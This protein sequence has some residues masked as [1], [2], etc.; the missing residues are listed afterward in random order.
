MEKA[1]GTKGLGMFMTLLIGGSLLLHRGR[2]VGKDTTHTRDHGW[3]HKIARGR[4]SQR[5]LTCFLVL[6]L[7]PREGE[8]AFCT[9]EQLCEEQTLSLQ[10]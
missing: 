2:I 4:V 6:R 10:F 1:S 3:T 8:R 9:S 5:F 7:A